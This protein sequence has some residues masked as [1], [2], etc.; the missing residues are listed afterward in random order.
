M[1]TIMKILFAKVAR[2][3][4]LNEVTEDLQ[5]V[6]KSECVLACRVYLSFNWIFTVTN[7]KL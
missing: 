7:Y 5:L 3:S 6:C 4:T 1:N 2:Q